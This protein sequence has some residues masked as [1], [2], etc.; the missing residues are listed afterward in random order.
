M[1]KKIIQIQYSETERVVLLDNGDVFR[2]YHYFK[3]N[4]GA[5][6]T[7]TWSEW[8]KVDYPFLDSK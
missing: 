1:A 8:E 2:K 4:G 6:K 3:S 5:Y 7:P